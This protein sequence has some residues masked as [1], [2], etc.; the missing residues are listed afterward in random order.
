M[1]SSIRILTSSLSPERLCR[2]NEQAEIHNSP[3]G[4]STNCPGGREAAEGALERNL[5][6]NKIIGLFAMQ[7]PFSTVGTVPHNLK[8]IAILK[9]P[10]LAPCPLPAITTQ[11]LKGEEKGEGYLTSQ[12]PETINAVP[13]TL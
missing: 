4:P 6:A 3:P 10:K 5:L 7:T 2:N 12:I 11:S 13:I 1:F 9:L 8:I